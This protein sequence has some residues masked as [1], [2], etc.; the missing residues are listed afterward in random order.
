MIRLHFDL[1]NMRQSV[2]QNG[3]SMQFRFGIVN[4]GDQRTA[5]M[6]CRTRIVQSPEIV[7]D[8]TVV[9]SGKA[10]VLTSNRNRSVNGRSAG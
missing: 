5:Q 10:T 9:L 2:R 1:L 4:S 3:D 6:Q 8:Q 7:K